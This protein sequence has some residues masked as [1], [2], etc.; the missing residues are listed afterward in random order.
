MSNLAQQSQDVDLYFE[1][2]LLAPDDAL[3]NTTR[4]AGEAGIPDHAVAPLQGA[5]LSILARSV[6]AQSILEIGTLAGYSTIWLA[7][8][9]GME[10][11][12]ITLEADPSHAKVARINLDEAGLGE[13]V[14]L[15]LGDAVQ[16]LREIADHRSHVFDFV[17]I[18]ADK[19]NNARYFDLAL[20]VTHPGS[21]ILVDNVVRSGTVVDADSDDRRVQGVRSL[22]SMLSHDPRIEATAIQTVGAKGYDGFLLARVL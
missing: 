18:D 1:E 6:D 22:I 8:A 16:S 20:R 14:T 11:R 3:S 15:I 13:R 17:F 10:G 19:E 9:A 5:L 2:A 21:L 12:V 4:R 7:R